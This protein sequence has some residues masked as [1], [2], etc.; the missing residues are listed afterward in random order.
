MS[1]EPILVEDYIPFTASHLFPYVPLTNALGL[2]GRILVLPVFWRPELFA[3]RCSV[4]PLLIPLLFNAISM[5]V[6]RGHARDIPIYGR[7]CLIIP[8]VCGGIRRSNTVGCFRLPTDI[9]RA[10][11][12]YLPTR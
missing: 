3:L 11:W 7:I 6:W 4:V 2:L 1:L 8:Y 9:F 10:I 12:G 5:V